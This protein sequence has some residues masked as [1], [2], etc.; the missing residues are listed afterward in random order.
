ME[1][2]IA[3]LTL[4]QDSINQLLLC[5]AW[6][7]FQINP[8]QFKIDLAVLHQKLHL[9]QQK[10]HPDKS[11]QNPLLTGISQVSAHINHCYIQL[12]QPLTRAIMLLKLHGIECDLSKAT[13]L[14]NNL[15]LQQ[16]EYREAIEEAINNEHELE[17]LHTQFSLQQNI[18]M[19]QITQLFQQ[20]QLT[21]IVPKLNELAFYIKLEST[22][23]NAITN[24][25]A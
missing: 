11:I 21:G 25:G 7:I 15:I 3:N 14:S 6:Q 2:D 20:T 19:Q 13:A 18:L 8:P 1:P 24:C 23:H 5:S 10:F 16:L 9:L 17:K 4:T 22:V 12:Q